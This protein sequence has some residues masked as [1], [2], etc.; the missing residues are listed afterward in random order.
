VYQQVAKQE[1]EIRFD[2]N[3][4][5]NLP[6]YRSYLYQWLNLGF[7][8]GRML[9]DLVDSQSGKQVFQLSFIERQRFLDFTSD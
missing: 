7:W 5:K 8:P 2:L 9:Y 4:L 3:Q 1:D 6:N